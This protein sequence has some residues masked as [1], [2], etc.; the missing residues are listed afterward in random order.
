MQ[1]GTLPLADQGRFVGYYRSRYW[2]IPQTQPTLPEAGLDNP[3]RV[4]IVADDGLLRQTVRGWLE[5]ASDV[6]VVGEAEGGPQTLQWLRE[7]QPDV[8]LLDIAA[9]TPQV[10]EISA[11]ARVIML[12][13]PGQE[14]LVLEA[15]RAGALGH[16]DKQNVQ[17][18]EAVAAVRTVSRGEAVLSS[19]LAGSILDEVA[20]GYRRPDSISCPDDRAGD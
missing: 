7:V 12:H 4:A 19:S 3:I 6:R 20:E 1:T 11:L 8:V 17:S 5:D 9:P 10:R 18:L 2:F 16:L 14:P 15:L 13:L